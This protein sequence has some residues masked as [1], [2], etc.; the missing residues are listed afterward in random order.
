MYPRQAYW[1]ALTLTAVALVIFGYKLLV[2]K[3]P[4]KPDT[5]VDV[6]D[7]EVQVTFTA[8]K[9]PV[10]VSL[11]LPQTRGRFDII[12]EHFISGEYGLAIQ[13]F[14]TNRKA[15]WSVR[16]ANGKQYLLYKATVRPALDAISQL[17]GKQPKVREVDLSMARRSK[18]AWVQ[19]CP[20]CRFKNPSNCSR[21]CR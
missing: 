20:K 7:I 3:L 12:D 11:Y 18:H 4:V 10:K 14:A 17:S 2:L 8:Q 5:T 6:W 16:Y 9:Q 1:L 19:N 15:I 13:Q 21:N